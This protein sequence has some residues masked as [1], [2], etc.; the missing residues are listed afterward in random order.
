MGFP[1]AFPLMSHRAMSIPLSIVVTNP[2]DPPPPVKRRYSLCHMRS[3]C[4]GFSPMRD[5]RKSCSK[6]ESLRNRN[7][8]PTTMLPPP[9]ELVASPIP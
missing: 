7:I 5:S 8:F 4:S 3:T 9:P 2:P 1:A 6:V